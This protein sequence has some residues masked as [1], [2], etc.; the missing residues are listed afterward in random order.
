MNKPLVSILVP[1]YNI[2]DY[3]AECLDSLLS[4]TL[5][6]IEIICVNDGSTDNS[7]EILEQYA[8]RDPRIVIVNKENGGLPS[9]RNAGIDA[10][11][12]IYGGF[13]DGDD[14][15]DERMFEKL[16]VKAKKVHADMV[17][18]GAE[19]YPTDKEPPRW[20]REA[21]SPQDNVFKGPSL[22]IF[23]NEIGSKPFLWRN[24]VKRNLIEDNH[25]RLDET[26]VVGEDLA[27]QAKL[28]T[29]ASKIAFMSDKFYKYRWSRP[30]S[31]M[32]DVRY[33]KD[34]CSRLKKH[35]YLLKRIGEFW[36]EQNVFEQT[37]SAFFNWS[38]DFIYWDII[39]LC[40][41]DKREIANSFVDLA[42]EFDLF[43]NISLLDDER[44]SHFDYIKYLTNGENDQPVLSVVLYINSAGDQVQR[45][46]DSIEEQSFSQTEIM[47]Y[48][49]SQDPRCNNRLFS[50]LNE[51]PRV[52]L[53]LV[54]SDKTAAEIYNDA[55]LSAKGK[56]ITFVKIFDYYTDRDYL[57]RLVDGFEI[58]KA[59]IVGGFGDEIF[60]IRAKTECQNK[61]FYQYAYDLSFLRKNKILF[62][63]YSLW[64][65][66]V[67]FTRC[68][69]KSEIICNVKQ[70]VKR[71][72]NFRRTSIFAIEAKL[73]LQAAVQLLTLAEKNDLTELRDRITDKFNNE[74]YTRLITDATFG[75][76]S[77]PA[78][79]K[80]EKERFNEDIFE[81]L[82]KINRCAVQ[83]PMGKS[84]LR[85]LERFVKLRYLFLDSAGKINKGKGD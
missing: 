61:D 82:V 50:L 80:K 47:I 73:L 30:N 70:G 23:F 53:R 16:Y 19:C 76:S 68:C 28:Y 36:K 27:F 12:G 39:R 51:D 72:D 66:K 31:I 64:T 54:D 58:E 13:V 14:V 69:I 37:K 62:S 20:L 67:F 59:D 55:I 40:A 10:A 48:D 85:T 35:I 11:R 84:M 56:Y 7:L 77:D 4:Q 75:F 22:S 1:V 2:A 79:I 8:K 15:V 24:F 34:Y 5:R 29:H 74:N 6:E 3:L 71:D 44:R 46:L 18:C 42:L 21:L 17:V 38:V 25:L 45:L 33:S 81:M 52:A 63:D 57:Q 60:G 9:A 49:H 83:S 78:C 43:G 32:N 65:G 41:S 26:I